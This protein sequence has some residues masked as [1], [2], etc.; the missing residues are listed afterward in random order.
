[1]GGTIEFND[2]LQL[3]IQQGFPKE[4]VLAKHLRKPFRAEDFKNRIFSFKGK[5]N[6]RLFQP[7]PTRVFLVQNI[8]GKWLYWGHCIVM[9]QTIDSNK[10][11]TSGKFVITKIY[12]P[13]HQKSMSRYEPK[14]GKEY[15]V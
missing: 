12:T 9:E 3:T 8:K 5:P 2:T 11:I 14:E 7:A 15:F 6:V 1:M 4:L 10:K 13:E